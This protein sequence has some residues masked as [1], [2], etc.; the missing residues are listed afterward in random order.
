MLSSVD[1]PVPERPTIGDV[2]ARVDRE[3]DAL[4]DVQHPVVGQPDRPRDV[5]ELEQAHPPHTAGS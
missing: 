3:G 2:L 4:Q 5:G 1:L